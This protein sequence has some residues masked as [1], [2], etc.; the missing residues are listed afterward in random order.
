LSFVGWLQNAWA[1]EIHMEFVGNKVS[2]SE[3]SLCVL[4]FFWEISIPSVFQMH[5]SLFFD[6]G[7]YE[8]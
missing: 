4:S 5:V 8:S 1:R 6:V 2:P 3:A 7:H